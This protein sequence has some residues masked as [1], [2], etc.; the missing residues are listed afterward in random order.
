MKKFIQV[1]SLLSL[2]V[3]FTAVGARAQTAYGTEVEIPFAF[4]V[5]DRSYDAGHYIV[6]VVR[7]TSGVTVLSIQ[8]TKNDKI[9]Q[10]LLNVNGDT[11]GSELKLFFATIGDRKFLNKVQ[12]PTSGYSVIRSKAEK[13]ARRANSGNPAAS[14]SGGANLF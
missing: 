2:L 7:Q 1:F 4:N 10:V 11:P 8:E 14:I 5:G 6:R 9:Q 13:E 12:T 3:V